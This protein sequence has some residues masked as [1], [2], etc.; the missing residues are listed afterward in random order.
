MSE[1]P[2]HLA[3]LSLPGLPP[4]RHPRA[5][6]ASHAVPSS[7]PL[8]ACDS[9]SYTKESSAQH[10]FNGGRTLTRLSRTCEAGRTHHIPGI[11]DIP[12]RYH[13]IWYD[14]RPMISQC[15]LDAHT[16]I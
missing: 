6:A 9:R 15:T 2:I 11:G 12:P 10:D 8:L 14:V 13:K 5:V 16:C 1:D 7:L 3:L 4:H